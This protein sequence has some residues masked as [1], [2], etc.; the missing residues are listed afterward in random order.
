MTG[1]PADF[2]SM[3]EETNIYAP[4]TAEREKPLEVD[5]HQ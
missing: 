2:N 3:K 5:T 4:Q 1:T